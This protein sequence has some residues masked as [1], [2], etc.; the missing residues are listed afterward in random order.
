MEKNNKI[1]EDEIEEW[2]D[3]DGY[4]GKYQVS[5]MGRVRNAVKGNVFNSTKKNKWGFLIIGL[6]KDKISNKIQLHRLVAIMFIDNPDGKECIIHIDGNK[7]NNKASNL[8]WFN[9]FE[10]KEKYQKKTKK[11]KITNDLSDKYSKKFELWLPVN[12][13]ENYQ[14]SNL[15]RIRS[16]N[17]GKFL[18][19]QKSGD[20]YRLT[21]FKTDYDRQSVAIHILVA[22]HF[23]VNDDPINKESVDHIDENKFNNKASNLRWVTQSQNSQYY[24][25][26]HKEENINPVLQYDHD[27]NLIKEWKHVREISENTNYKRSHI[28]NTLIG[29][30]NLAYGYIWKY[31]NPKE[32]K[33]IQFEQDEVFKNCGI[34]DGYNMGNYEV[35]NYGKVRSLYI[36]QIMEPQMKYGY[37]HITFKVNNSQPKAFFVHRLVAMLFIDGRTEEKDI[38]NHKDRNKTNNDY[39]NLEWCTQQYNTHHALA[40]KVIQI[41]MKTGNTVNTFD[42]ITNACKSLGIEKEGMCV[43]IAKCCKG[44]Q[45]SAYGYK[46]KYLNE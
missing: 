38:V 5:D 17:S 10:F 7:M 25:N 21:L 35:S 11:I 30:N 28:Y 18:K 26:N 12:G 44:K 27:N 3:I 33:E 43:G 19:G 20:Y 16:K 29:K 34:I 31:K 2:K 6:Y 40:K 39:K 36:N 8:Q 13:Y 1:N 9:K 37:N 45:S 42:S 32:I 22:S 15:G 24:H 23:I 41:D 4:D 46:W 14:V